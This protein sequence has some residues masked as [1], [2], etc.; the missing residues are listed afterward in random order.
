MR[1][2][3]PAITPAW[4]LLPEN[5]Q[6]ST[7]TRVPTLLESPGFFGVQFPGPGKSWKM[8]LVLE[9]PRNLSARS[10]NFLGYDNEWCGRR[11]K[12]RRCRCQNLRV[13]TS[14]LI[15]QLSKYSLPHISTA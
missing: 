2:R 7:S 12:W 3:M 8:G 5:V 4:N 6:K 15:V 13:R 1:F 11:T 9:S 14:L 10:W